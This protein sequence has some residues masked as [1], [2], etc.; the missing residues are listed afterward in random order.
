MVLLAGIYPFYEK[1]KKRDARLRRL[2]L[3]F[4]EC[5][6]LLAGALSTGYSIENAFTVSVQE[7]CLLYGEEGLM[8][9]EMKRMEAMIRINY[10]VE[11]VLMEFGERSGLEDVK[12]F[13]QVFV[14]AKRSG[15]Q[16]GDILRNTAEVIRQKVQIQEEIK[17][18]TAARQFEQKIMNMLPC[19]IIGYMNLTSPGFLD[20][21]Y[22]TAIGK[23]VMTLCLLVCLAAM[24]V[25]GKI[26]DLQ[27]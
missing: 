15:G 4:K 14:V 25:A 27:V 8:F 2:T 7:L 19:G 26:L 20:L 6:L 12:N 21:M 18:L 11:Q 3:E 9:A 23:I 17:T 24:A 1:Q 10:P 5:A 22:E 13:A 16:L